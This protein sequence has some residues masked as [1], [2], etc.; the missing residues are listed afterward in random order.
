MIQE[1]SE[2]CSITYYFCSQ[3]IEQ[4]KMGTPSMMTGG[5]SRLALNPARANNRSTPR[6]DTVISHLTLCSWAQAIAARSNSTATGD[7]NCP[8]PAEGV[9]REKSTAANLDNSH[10]SSEHGTG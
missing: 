9:S 8:K 4:A 10:T 7:E 3:S 2:L 6:G 5:A 1:F